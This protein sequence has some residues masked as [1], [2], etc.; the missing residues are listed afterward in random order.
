V[1]R[2][3]NYRAVKRLD[4]EYGSVVHPRSYIFNRRTEIDR[5]ELTDETVLEYRQKF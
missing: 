2:H 4:E 1:R 5:R 3:C